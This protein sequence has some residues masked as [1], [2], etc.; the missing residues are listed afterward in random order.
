VTRRQL[1]PGQPCFDISA[2]VDLLRE[3]ISRTDALVHATE[4]QLERFTWSAGEED[5]EADDDRR[6]EHLAHLLGAAKEAARAAVVAGDQIAA[7]L[8]KHRGC[9]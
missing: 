8:L 7:D 3:F 6:L 5:E 2:A 1:G 9:V 4:Y